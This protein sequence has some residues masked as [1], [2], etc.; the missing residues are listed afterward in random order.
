MLAS[1]AT[2]ARRLAS[3]ILAMKPNINTELSSLV[4]LAL[5]SDV[6]SVVVHRHEAGGSHAVAGVEELLLPGGLQHVLDHGGQVELG[7]LVP[8]EVPEATPGVLGVE[9]GVVPAVGVAPVVAQPD[10]VAGVSQ[11]VS[12][13]LGWV[14]HHP[15]SGG[16]EQAVLHEDD[17]PL[18]GGV[19]SLPVRDPVEGEDVAVL[20]HRPVLLGGVAVVPDEDGLNTDQSDLCLALHCSLLPWGRH[21]GAEAGQV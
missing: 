13:P 11:D 1:P 12:E 4:S 14:R 19:G 9:D 7:H 3:L 15:V 17:G 10:V 20:R 8:G 18:H 16:A 6:R 21:S 5:L 2:G